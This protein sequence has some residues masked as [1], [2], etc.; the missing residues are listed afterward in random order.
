M[1][2]EEYYSRKN[3]L[4]APKDLDAFDRANWYTTQIKELQKSLSK[5]DLKIVLQEE[6]NWQNKMQS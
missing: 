2:L 4:D 1:T 5:T 6:S 3:N